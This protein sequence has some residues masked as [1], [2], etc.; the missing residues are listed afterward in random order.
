[1][2][3]CVFI[4]AQVGA[5]G[6]DRILAPTAVIFAIVSYL[7]RKQEI[8]GWL[9]Y[10]CYCIVG[11]LVISL[12]DIVRHPQ[13]FF[14]Q[15]AQNSGFHLALILAVFPRLIAVI[16]MMTYTFVLLRTREWVWVERLRLALL[17]AAII[18]L[19]SLALDAGFFPRSLF[20]NAAR[21]IGLALWTLYFSV[22]E[23]VRRVF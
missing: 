5:T 6:L 8:G 12:A 1:M 21:W 3:S 7:R 19:I 9:L 17:V 20:R 22:S 15:Q 10:F 16:A 2:N 18:A 13:V 14:H 4:L 11:V 23:R